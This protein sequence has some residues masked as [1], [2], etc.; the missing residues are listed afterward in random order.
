MAE[1]PLAAEA[2]KTKTYMDNDYDSAHTLK[3][4]AKLAVQVCTIHAR[5]GFEMGNWISNSDES[6]KNSRC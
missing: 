1:F 5:G 3:E 4:V 2:I 6:R